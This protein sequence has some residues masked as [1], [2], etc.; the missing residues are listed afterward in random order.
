MTD[1]LQQ[2][3][4][5]Q[6]QNLLRA[7]E[8]NDQAAQ[9]ASWDKLGHLYSAL[10]DYPQS[11]HAYEQTAAIAK[12]LKDAHFLLHLGISFNILREYPQSFDC[13][14]QSIQISLAH[15]D[16]ER[17]ALE[18]LYIL[19]DKYKDSGHDIPQAMMYYQQALDLARKI[20]DTKHQYWNLRALGRCHEKLK[21]T[22]QALHYYKE[23]L[24]VVR[25]DKDQ[26]EEATLLTDIAKIFS[27]ADDYEQMTSY[28]EQALSVAQASEDLD[29]KLHVLIGWGHSY[30]NSDEPSKALSYYQQ[31]LVLAR[32]QSDQSAESHCLTIIAD[33]YENQ[34]DWPQAIDNYQ[35]ILELTDDNIQDTIEGVFKK[36]QLDYRRTVALGSLG[37][38]YE[39]QNDI[40]QALNYLE[41]ALA[42][43]TIRSS[44]Q[45]LNE[46]ITVLRQKLN[47][48]EA[49][50]K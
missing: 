3:I 30:L 47:P 31:A 1:D 37:E 49:N 7:Q 11:V 48:D 19:A 39:E 22:Q 21:D 27:R 28:F 13:L 40:P 18:A 33:Y 4:A 38:I 32:N 14:K 17:D 44:V 46:R 23:G 41:Q 43:T 6:K 35:Q 16:T 36:G 50:K 10:R 9:M 15:E 25:Q 29:A 20:A 45:K 42:N 5:K 24:K 34:K 2:Q 12:Q 26:S 8:T